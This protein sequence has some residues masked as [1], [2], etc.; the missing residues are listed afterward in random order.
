[1]AEKKKT[2]IEK[3]NAFILG[4][5]LAIARPILKIKYKTTYSVA[6]L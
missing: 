2:I 6:L 5:A 3:P 1:M 4:L